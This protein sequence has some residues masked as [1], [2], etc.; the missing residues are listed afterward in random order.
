MEPDTTS[1]NQL[2]REYVLEVAESLGMALALT[3][4]WA[5]APQTTEDLRLA[6]RDLGNKVCDIA[7]FTA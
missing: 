7:E 6:W 4:S 5:L 2:V 3:I 1:H